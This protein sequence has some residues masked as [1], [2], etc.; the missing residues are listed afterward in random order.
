MPAI[1]QKVENE[2]NV[3]MSINYDDHLYAISYR[4]TDMHYWRSSSAH[5]RRLE[6][7]KKKKKNPHQNPL[8]VLLG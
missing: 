6:K 3:K 2:Q 5:Q 4:Q 1:Y 7:K 8:S